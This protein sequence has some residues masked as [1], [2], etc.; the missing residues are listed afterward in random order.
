[1]VGHTPRSGPL[2]LTHTRA[3]GRPGRTVP[4]L[5]QSGCEQLETASV[6]PRAAKPKDPMPS[7]DRRL[8]KGEPVHLATSFAPPCFLHSLRAVV[9]LRHHWP[10][11]RKDHCAYYEWT[12][13]Q[14][15]I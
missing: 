6:R 3:I 12:E 15:A 5:H 7:L 14:C 4:G 8:Y 1:M 10:T 2:R 13:T 9:H 11:S